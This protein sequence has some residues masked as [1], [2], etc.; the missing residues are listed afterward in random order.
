MPRLTAL[1][2]ALSTLVFALSDGLAGLGEPS[3]SGVTAALDRSRAA[4]RAPGGRQD[5]CGP[6]GPRRRAHSHN[7][8]DHRPVDQ[9][10]H[11]ALRHCFTSVEVD[12]RLVDAQLRLGHDQAGGHG[13]AERYL[14]PLLD[15]VQRN[16]GSVY[17]GYP[18]WHGALDL[19][20][21]LKDGG[22]TKDRAYQAL[23][24]LLRSRYSAM[25][26]RYTNGRELPGA[27][28]V[29][30]TGDPSA[31]TRDAIA[32]EPER[33]VAFDGGPSL[34]ERYPATVMPVISQSWNDVV[35]S[36][37]GSDFDKLRRHHAFAADHGRTHRVWGTPQRTGSWLAELRAGVELVETDD[38]P[39]LAQL[40][41]QTE[42]GYAFP[43][44][45]GEATG[46]VRPESGS[47][48]RLAIAVSLR[49]PT[50]GCATVQALFQRRDG[51]TETAREHRTC[52]QGGPAAVTFTA[53]EATRTA[54]SARV[55]LRDDHGHSG[56][57][58]FVASGYP[59]TRR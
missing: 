49:P 37:L 2:A 14:D 42:D 21:D 51:S 35:W 46:V 20:V 8:E 53:A 26:T 44:A 30:V 4:Q 16:G 9:W 52:Q 47:A 11:E 56:S 55:T 17:P 41:D 28:R 34:V 59:P 29:V 39:A 25:L 31:Q 3:T 23:R 7:D 5:G 54:W 1:A 6:G 24:E 10:L 13:L 48:G 27:V 43:L 15:R 12:V 19:V 57:D 33:L 32:A 45:A 38:I 58:T 22:A 36:G 40:L 50:G 18:G